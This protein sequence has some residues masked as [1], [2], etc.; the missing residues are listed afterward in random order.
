M[1]QSQ[2]YPARMGKVCSIEVVPSQCDGCGAGVVEARNHANA[3]RSTFN[4]VT[5]S[6]FRDFH[7]SF[8]S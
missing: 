7:L 3:G 4:E 5:F 1:F 8:T 6:W 2:L